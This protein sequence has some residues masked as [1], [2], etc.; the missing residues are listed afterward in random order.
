MTPPGVKILRPRTEGAKYLM[1]SVFPPIEAVAWAGGLWGNARPAVTMKARVYF[2]TAWG[3]FSSQVGDLCHK[4]TTQ[5]GDLLPVLSN[6][7]RL[8]GSG[9]KGLNYHKPADGDLRSIGEHD[10]GDFG[11]GQHVRNLLAGQC[12]GK[13]THN[14][15]SAEPK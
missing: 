1:A 14:L 15:L 6:R 4:Y 2:R 13:E 8:G 7:G 3:I 10:V 11:I 5:V 9:W 12:V